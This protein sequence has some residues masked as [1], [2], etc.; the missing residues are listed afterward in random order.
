M[1]DINQLI[2]PQ[3]GGMTASMG[4]D[5]VT[6]QATEPV[7]GMGHDPNSPFAGD[8]P[9]DFI[10]PEALAENPENDP[11]EVIAGA[12]LELYG[13]HMDGI[14]DFMEATL[15]KEQVEAYDQA[16][17]SGDWS[18]V[19]PL[20]EQVAEEYFQALEQGIKFELPQ[21]QVTDEEVQTEMDNLANMEPEGYETAMNIL[22]HAESVPAGAE[23]DLL[24]AAAEF[25]AGRADP[26][27]ST[28]MLID[29]YGLETLI[30]LYQK[31]NP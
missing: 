7:V 23:R 3:R 5:E 8:L 31:W 2:T 26:R 11:D 17:D 1:T 16:I 12:V 18:S 15:P 25:H 6:G 29:K 24:M 4:Y 10:N 21:D 27:E 30:P 22:G 20:L 14:L 13:D 19:M 28:Q 9:Q